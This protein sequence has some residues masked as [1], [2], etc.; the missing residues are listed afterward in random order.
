F[1]LDMLLESI[2]SALKRVKELLNGINKRSVSSE[3]SIHV[4]D[5]FTAL[6]LCCIDRLYED[7]GLEVMET[8]HKIPSTAL[9]VILIHSS[10]VIMVNGGTLPKE[11]GSRVAKDVKNTGIRDKAPV[12]GIV[13]DNVLP[14]S[15]TELSAM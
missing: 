7:H 5:H 1:E 6:N 14:R 10:K 4:E 9:P 12:I 3:G 13:N 11:D 2:N 8:M 15:S